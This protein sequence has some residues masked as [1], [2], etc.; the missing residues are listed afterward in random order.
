[1]EETIVDQNVDQ[2][3]FQPNDQSYWLKRSF[4]VK[5][6]PLSIM[7]FSTQVFPLEYQTTSIY[8]VHHPTRWW[9]PIVIQIDDPD[10]NIDPCGK[11]LKITK[12]SNFLLLTKIW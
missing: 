4:Y 6:G 10:V 5:I 8:M 9:P 11:I 1:M 3:K 2:E 12:I 7:S